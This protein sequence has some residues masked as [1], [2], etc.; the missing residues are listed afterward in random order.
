MQ[1]TSDA[2]DVDFLAYASLSDHLRREIS[3]TATEGVCEPDSISLTKAEVCKPNV[4]VLMKQNILWLEV[5]IEDVLGMEVLEGEHKL[6]DDPLSLLFLQL[7]F[8]SQVLAQ[9]TAAA[10]VQAHVQVLL[11]LEGVP[12]LHYEWVVGLPKD[13]ALAYC[14]AQLS[15]ESQS[16]F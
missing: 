11:R 4:S 6:S 3:G 8:M 1:H 13:I 7:L 16:P 9:I 5:P 2:I 12:E 10:V 14:I 15:L